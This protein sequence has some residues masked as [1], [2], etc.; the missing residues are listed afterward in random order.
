MCATSSTHLILLGWIILCG[1]SSSYEASH[2]AVFSNFL[3]F[4]PCSAPVFSTPC[5]LIALINKTKGSE[6]NDN[7]RFFL[8]IALQPF[9]PWLL[10]QFLWSYT[11]WVGQLERGISS[12]QG[13]YLRIEQHN[14]KKKAF[15]HPCL[16]L[17]SNPRSQCSRGRGWFM[18]QTARTLCLTITTITW[19]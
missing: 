10:F 11:Q 6:L 8:P 9:G 7:N 17:D 5:S 3:L 18:P 2:Y 14:R 19:V 4:H 16:E 12:S 15:R 1:K 13:P